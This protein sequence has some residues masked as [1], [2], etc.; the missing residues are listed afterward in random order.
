MQHANSMKITSNKII[1]RKNL[2]QRSLQC[3]CRTDENR[4]HVLYFLRVL[5]F[6]EMDT[7]AAQQRVH[8]LQIKFIYGRILSQSVFNFVVRSIKKH[9]ISLLAAQHN[10]HRTQQHFRQQ[11][12]CRFYH[13]RLVAPLAT[14]NENKLLIQK[15]ILVHSAKWCN[16]NSSRYIGM[17]SKS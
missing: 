3:F 2:Q 14:M 16:L 9:A 13:C 12:Q 17:N 15:S 7:S 5:C 11:V 8:F 4:E 1:E 10:F 6:S